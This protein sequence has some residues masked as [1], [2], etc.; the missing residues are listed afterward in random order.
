MSSFPAKYSGLCIPCGEDIK[1]GEYLI[2]HPDAG[3]IHED[4][5]ED[6]GKASQ[7]HDEPVTRGPRARPVMPHGKTA[8]DRCNQCFIVH[9]LGQAGCY[10]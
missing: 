2:T 5:A 7:I 4:C 6:V 10:E 1:P 9:S 8:S 3:F